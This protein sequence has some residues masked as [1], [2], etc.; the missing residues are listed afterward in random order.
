LQSIWGLV[1]RANQYVDQTAPFKLAKDPAQAK[2]LD[3]VLYNLTETCRVL[4]VLLWPFLPGT[5]VKIYAQLGLT[6]TPD[7][8]DAANWGYLT[9]GH[10]IGEPAPLFPRKEA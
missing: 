6:G 5:A 8:L 1:T 2:R 9:A 10:T 7:K 4:A 3:E